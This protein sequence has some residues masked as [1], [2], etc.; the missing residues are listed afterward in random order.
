MKVLFPF[1]GDTVGGSHH[2]AAVLI[3][4]LPKYDVQPVCL[5]HRQGPLTEFLR[6]Y[7]IDAIVEPTL[8]L[9]KGNGWP[10]LAAW[11]MGIPRLCSWIWRLKPEVVHVNDGRMAITWA[12]A[13]RITRTAL[14][15]HQ[16]TRLAPSRI[17]QFSLSQ[18]AHILAISRYVR[19]TLP[20]EL[21]QRTTVIA[22][23]FA[24]PA[25]LN[26]GVARAALIDEL[27]LNPDWPVIACIGT[28]QPQKRPLVAIEAIARLSKAGHQASL[29]LVG[30]DSGPERAKVVE[31]I[32][33]AGLSDRV[34]VLGFRSDVDRLL[35][36]SDM[37]LATAVDE[38]HGRA[39]VEAM[40]AGTPVVA[41]DS[42]GHVEVIRDR[43]TGLLARQ[44][45]PDSFVEALHTLIEQ[46]RK[47]ID[48]A[49][50]ARVEAAGTYSVDRHV[51]AV[52]AVY[53]TVTA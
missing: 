1:V 53:R 5:V 43:A 9:W 10:G 15:T 6:Q 7:G 26:R 39:I 34:R 33:A 17:T 38:G 50:A 4:A 2:S 40:L 16:R 11:G 29:L 35:A 42:G 20:P 37:L 48:L 36:G 25:S 23:P 13:A 46:P 12:M 31:A 28:L 22:N 18:S 21:Q 52:V 44:D 45:Q 27:G 32:R 47:A 8:P 51:E 14:I 3:S 49:E 24:S 30:R 19:S 41:S